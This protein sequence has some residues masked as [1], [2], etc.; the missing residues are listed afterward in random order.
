MYLFAELKIM[1]INLYIIGAGG[2]GR[3]MIATLS[4]YKRNS[5]FKLTGFI[6]DNQPTGKVINGL[7]V[8][9]GT[10]F[11]RKIDSA[12]VLIGVGNS[13]IREQIFSNLSE[14]I[15]S[16]PTIIHPNASIHSIEFVNIGKGC[17]IADGCILTTNISIGNF[18]YLLPGVTLSHDT[19]I[20][21]FCT[22]MPGVRIS[23]GATLGNRVVIG[24]GTIITKPISICD[25]AVIPPGRIITSNVD[26]YLPNEI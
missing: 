5:K 21:N 10:E 8:L 6:D 22:L 23:S 11:L 9:G 15:I 7:T 17:Y 19:A 1:P 14:H 16:F 12:N 25:G 2:L 18:T 13:S 4:F 20:D 3:E 26:T 24:T